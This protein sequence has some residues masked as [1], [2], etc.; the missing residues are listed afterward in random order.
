MKNSFVFHITKYKKLIERLSGD[1]VK[2][3]ML[4]MCEYTNTGN[5]PDMDAITEIAFAGV[6]GQMDEDNQK[7][8][9]TCLARSAAGKRGGRPSKTEKAN[10]FEKSNC[11]S[12][13]QKKQMV[14]KKAKEAEYECD[15][16]SECDNDV[17]VATTRAYAKT[18]QENIGIITPTI[19]TEAE[20]YIDDG[21]EDEVISLALKESVDA[22]AKNW[23]YAKAVL[24]AW[25]DK[26][27]F[28][29]EQAKA[30]NREFQNRRRRP[31]MANKKDF[32]QRE[33]TQEDLEKR[34]AD[35]FAE[36]ERMY[37][38]GI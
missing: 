9:E 21:M 14:L 25:L 37:G 35:N 10:G 23:K 29:A 7:W 20:S 36:L 12:E 33:Y 15:S 11:F 26:G 28:T 22:G 38:N 6:Q 13:K 1:Q 32:E 16:D 19:V 27:I 8:A 5:V 18:Y 3:L 4:A 2:A 24:T 17:A 31:G 34:K 30:A